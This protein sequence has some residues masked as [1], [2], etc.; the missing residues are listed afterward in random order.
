MM[1]SAESDSSDARHGVVLIVEDE[2]DVRTMLGEILEGEGYPVALANNGQDA[3]DYLRR[4][5]PPCM[6]VLDL[7]MPVLSGSDF[8]AQQLLDPAL[9]QIPVLV[10]SGNENAQQKSKALGAVGCFEKPIKIDQLL[11][12]LAQHC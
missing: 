8:R 6:I 10:V 2:E 1:E 11:G 5:P 7:I 4:N 3:L 9:A 12:A